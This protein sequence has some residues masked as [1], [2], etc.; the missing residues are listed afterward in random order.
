MTNINI[1][2]FYNTHKIHMAFVCTNCH[3]VQLEK[4]LGY[5]AYWAHW[6]ADMD[7][8]WGTWSTLL[9]S[10]IWLS[11]MASKMLEGRDIYEE[12]FAISS[13][14]TTFNFELPSKHNPADWVISFNLR[15]N[16]DVPLERVV[17]RLNIKNLKCTSTSS[18]QRPPTRCYTTL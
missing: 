10:S 18:W 9:S 4:T 1:L 11:I 14:I 8:Y 17:D 6:R 12:C 5:V 16:H 7:H 3:H 15:H 13:C 2:W